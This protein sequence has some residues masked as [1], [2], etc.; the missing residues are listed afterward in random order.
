MAEKRERREA[1]APGAELGPADAARAYV[2]VGDGII[3]IQ[4]PRCEE[5]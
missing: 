5:A 1:P 2:G 3:D 4:A